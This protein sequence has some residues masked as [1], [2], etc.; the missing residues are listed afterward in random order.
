MSF[1]IR[2]V[3][4]QYGVAMYVPTKGV[5]SEGKTYEYLALCESI[6]E[7]RKVRQVVVANLGRKDLLD[8]ARIDAMVRALDPLALNAAVF[9]LDDDRQ[10]PQTSLEYGPMPILQRLWEDLGIG[11]LLRKASAER[12]ATAP[13]ERA[14]FAMVAARFLHPA[15]KRDT[16]RTWLDSVYAPDLKGLS[17]HHLYRAMDLL[18]RTKTRIERVQWGRVRTIFRPSV[19]LVLVDTTNTYLYGGERAS[20]AQ[21]GKSK[22]KR[23]DRRLVSVGLLVTRD[24]VPIGMVSDEILAHLREEKI[25]YVAGSRLTREAKAALAYRG[26]RW[27]EVADLGIRIKE[28]AIG[29]EAYVV[30]HNP[31]EEVHDRKRRQEILARLRAALRRNPSGSNLLRNS[32]YRPYVRLGGRAVTIDREAI[33]RRARLDG[34]YVLRANTALSG[35]EIV[36]AYRQLYRVERAS[37]ELK[38]PFEMRPVYHW[39]DRRIRG[40]IVVCF[41]AYV[42]EMALRQ[43]LGKGE[44]VSEKDYRA[45]M[46]DV[47]K[48]KVVEV[49]TRRGRYVMRTTLKGRA[50]EAFA[51]VGM[52]VPPK[53]LEGSAAAGST[54]PVNVM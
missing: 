4:C 2:L 12:S 25:E 3:V 29:E 8:P 44:V 34:K 31:E 16:L 22:E 49:Q 23:Y 28:L 43:A 47:R 50:F 27:R 24:G 32:L 39:V 36:R 19:D 42:L 9:D 13:L 14:A 6:R 38:G 54:E 21:Y 1:A 20:L 7:G 51:A 41:L 53:V 17:L 37:R 52:R 5:K 10:G 40:H 11:P 35:E 48:L 33:R 15:S 30:V 45:V 26:E 18:E 46:A